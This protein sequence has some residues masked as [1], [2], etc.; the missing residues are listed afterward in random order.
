MKSFFG[1]HI[2]VHVPNFAILAA[3]LYVYIVSSSTYASNALDSGLSATFW[4]CAVQ[5]VP[6]PPVEGGLKQIPI[7]FIWQSM[8]PVQQRWSTF[9][10][11]GYAIFVAL[12]HWRHFWKIYISFSKWIIKILDLSTQMV[13]I[14][15]VDGKLYYRI[16]ILIY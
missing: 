6:N 3:T 14:K 7:G 13:K 11:E 8:H 2:R 12:T 10:L 16:S 9:E 4:C 15:S 1:I 5:E